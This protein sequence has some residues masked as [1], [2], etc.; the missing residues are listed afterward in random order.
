M[1]SKFKVGDKV[2]V[3]APGKT[4][5]HY[6]VKFNELGFKDRV[7]NRSF[8]KYTLA[9]VFGVTLH[10][11][12]NY[13]ETLVA[14]RDRFSNESL[15]SE[16]GI[17]LLDEI[18]VV[19]EK[20]KVMETQKLSRQ[21]L[22][23]IHSVAC[24]NWKVNLENYSKRNTLEDFIELTNI[25]VDHMFNACTKEQLPIVSKYLKQDD[26]S[27]DLSNFTLTDT[28]ILQIRIGG[29]NENKAFLLSPNYDWKI[30]KDEYGKLCLIPTK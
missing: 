23:E 25:E 3:I 29:E 15:I 14:I 18:E 10:D 6:D 20:E 21:G 1:T 5:E 26:G 13:I 4:Y 8:G 2:R 28:S 17:E 27:V 9:E 7:E 19:K 16:T 12:P 24:T 11:N 30:Q 22:K